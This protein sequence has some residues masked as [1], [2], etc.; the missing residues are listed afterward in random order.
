MKDLSQMSQ[1]GYERLLNEIASLL[2]TCRR[3][4]KIESEERITPNIVHYK[5]KRKGAFN[6]YL[7]TA[8][9][10]GNRVIFEN[11]GLIL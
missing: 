6:R 9:D 1:V 7:I 10:F 2:R 11:R 3:F 5:V 4:V 8:I